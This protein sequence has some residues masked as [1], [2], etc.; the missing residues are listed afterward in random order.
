M[1]NSTDQ[2]TTPSQSED[3]TNRGSECC[4]RLDPSGES[5]GLGGRGVWGQGQVTLLG[6]A[7]HPTVPNGNYFCTISCANSDNGGTAETNDHFC[8]HVSVMTS[9]AARMHFDTRCF[10]VSTLLTQLSYRAENNVY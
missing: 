2:P 10:H 7:A 6:D 8:T 5:K 4:R 1:P 3:S 9:V